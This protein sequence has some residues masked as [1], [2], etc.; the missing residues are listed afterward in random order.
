MLDKHTAKHILA[1]YRKRLVSG[2]KP[3]IEWLCM[4]RGFSFVL[5]DVVHQED[6]CNDHVRMERLP[7]QES[8]RK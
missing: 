4:N 2:R 3:Y 8:D 6:A 5:A 7:G 1:H